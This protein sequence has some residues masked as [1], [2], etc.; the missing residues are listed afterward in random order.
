MRYQLFRMYILQPV[1]SVSQNISELII[2]FFN[3]NRMIKSE[4]VGFLDSN[5]TR[6]HFHEII[7]LC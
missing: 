1:E 5:K 2:N 6:A 4:P 7:I 3:E